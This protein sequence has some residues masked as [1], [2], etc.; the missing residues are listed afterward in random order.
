MS[1]KITNDEYLQRSEKIH[2][3]KYEYIDE[4]INAN[5]KLKIKCK[6]CSFI[7]E[8]RPADH[9]AGRGCPKCAHRK[10]SRKKNFGHDD[11]LEKCR[12][13]HGDMT[14]F[15]YLSDYINSYTKIK[16]KCLE[17]GNIFK[18]QAINHYR[19]QG[20]PKCSKKKNTMTHI[21]FLKKALLIHGSKYEYIDSY[22][23]SSKKIRIR[24][25]KCNDVFRQTPNNHLKGHGCP[26]CKKLKAGLTQVL[27][28]EEFLKKAHKI[29]KDS[30]EYLTPYKRSKEKIEIK[31]LKCGTIFNQKPNNH[32]RGQGCP[33]C[34]TNGF[35]PDKP[36]IL[37]YLKD[38]ETGLYKIGITNKSSIEERFGKTFCSKRAIAL[39]EQSFLNG[40][41]ALEYEQEILEQFAYARCTNDKWPIKLGGRTEFFKYNVLNIKDN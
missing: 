35:N 5:T 25:K 24:C 39:K 38:T 3:S 28:P 18:Q 11:F 9:W 32:L 2:G 30:F 33:N 37:Y 6:I 10:T 12:I 29:H 7:F 1:K 13:A 26:N 36:A 41:E 14:K 21:D 27:S 20:C 19:G 40:Q 34:S 8:Q 4:Y 17:C 15:E 22:E 16:I 23:N 31:C